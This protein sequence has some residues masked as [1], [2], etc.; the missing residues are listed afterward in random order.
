M[1][2][3]I[4]GWT[5]RKNGRSLHKRPGGQESSRR[6]VYRHIQRGSRACIG[7]S[8]RR[9]KRY[10][11]TSRRTYILSSEEKYICCLENN[12]TTW[13][14][15]FKHSRCHSRCTLLRTKG[16]CGMQGSVKLL[17]IAPWSY[18]AQVNG[19]LLNMAFRD[20]LS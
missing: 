12:I 5:S 3:A 11:G 1:V 13:I 7:S 8:L 14:G 4:S 15:R 20:K 9:S 17:L 2:N 18:S 6:R 10:G 16:C 19:H